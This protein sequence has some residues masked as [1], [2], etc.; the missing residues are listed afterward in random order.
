MKK[1]IS[2]LLAGLM[3]TGL[4]SINGCATMEGLGKDIEALGESIQDKVEENK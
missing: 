4:L 1:N 3:L 2:L